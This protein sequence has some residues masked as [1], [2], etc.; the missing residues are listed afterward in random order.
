VL[1]DALL[2][3]ALV[4]GHIGVAAEHARTH[5]LH[6]RQHRR[7]QRFVPRRTPVRTRRH[8]RHHPHRRRERLIAHGVDGSVGSVGG[9]GVRGHLCQIDSA[10]RAQV[11]CEAAGHVTGR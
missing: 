5:V 2:D 8:R 4:G 1:V 10:P 3:P 11:R 6:E 9:V 7:A